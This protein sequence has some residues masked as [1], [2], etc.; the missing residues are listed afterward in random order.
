[1]YWDLKKRRIINGLTQQDMSD[2]LNIS[3]SA[4]NLK[5]N[6][7]RDF[8]MEEVRAILDILKCKYEDIFFDVSVKKKNDKFTKHNNK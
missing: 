7:I 4:Y 2:K 3:L 5:E 6:G 8:T 1:M